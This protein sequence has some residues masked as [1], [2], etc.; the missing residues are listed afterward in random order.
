MKN[1]AY[2]AKNANSPLCKD[3]DTGL[4]PGA[5]QALNKSARRD[6]TRVRFALAHADMIFQY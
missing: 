5:R 2:S 3:A 4:S 6:A 1:I